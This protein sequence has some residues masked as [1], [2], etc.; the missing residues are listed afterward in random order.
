MQDAA[1][2]LDG[3]PASP[4]NELAAL[5]PAAA[6]LDAQCRHGLLAEQRAEFLADGD[7]FVE[8]SL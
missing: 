3:S 6:T 5:P 8:R 1:A 4:T 7:Q 2:C